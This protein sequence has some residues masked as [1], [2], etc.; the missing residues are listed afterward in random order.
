MPIDDESSETWQTCTV[1][2]IGFM[3][4]SVWVR[5]IVLPTCAMRVFV[6]DGWCRCGGAGPCNVQV[7]LE[8][9]PSEYECVL[10][11]LSAGMY[12][13]LADA[14]VDI[15]KIDHIKTNTYCTSCEELCGGFDFCTL[16]LP[17]A[18]TAS[19]AVMDVEE[20]ESTMGWC[21]A[22][23]PCRAMESPY[24]VVLKTTKESSIVDCVYL[25]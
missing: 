7:R 11:A 21:H 22:C 16:R 25:Q 10:S 4:C 13:S 14:T 15:L 23:S 1:S 24:V 8:L 20:S 2:V 6:M 12:G 19:G 3:L 5:S 18:H 9:W 17:F